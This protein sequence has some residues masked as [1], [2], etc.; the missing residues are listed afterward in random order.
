MPKKCRR[1]Q[2][3]RRICNGI[4]EV[5]N[6]ASKCSWRGSGIG[7]RE[8]TVGKHHPVNRS[9]ADKN[10]YL[11]EATVLYPSPMQMRRSSNLTVRKLRLSL[12]TRSLP[13]SKGDGLLGHVDLAFPLRKA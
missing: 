1:G 4:L 7:F 10:A 13:S 8:K 3:T 9:R 6:A 12:I 2:R 11:S 5:T